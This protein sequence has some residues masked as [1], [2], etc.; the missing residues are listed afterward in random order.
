MGETALAPI[1][2]VRRFTRLDALDHPLGPPQV[3][4]SIP[5][6]AVGS[7]LGEVANLRRYALRPTDAAVASL[8]NSV[9]HPGQSF[10]DPNLPFHALQPSRHYEMLS[11]PTMN[12][13]KPPW[14]KLNR[15]GQGGFVRLGPLYVRCH[16][17]APSPT[18]RPNSLRYSFNA[19]LIMF[20]WATRRRDVGGAIKI[21]LEYPNPPMDGSA[22]MEH[23]TPER[24]ALAT[25]DDGRATAR[26][27]VSRCD[28]MIE[29]PGVLFRAVLPVS[30][31]QSGAD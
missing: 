7:Y 9:R 8:H 29:P 22:L 25:G 5:S 19:P 14:V 4:S 3:S 20:R 16:A 12:G 28:V 1:N 23:R 17:N 18:S 30:S 31:G 24:V 11:G 13:A 15:R 26:P 21:T 2:Q 27:R 10:C 6:G